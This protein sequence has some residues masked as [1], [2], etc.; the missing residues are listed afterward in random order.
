MLK[1]T[2]AA[3]ALMG[4]VNFSAFAD[5]QHTISISGSTSV[6]RV[7]DVLAETYN[8]KHENIF[9]AVHGTGSSAGIAAVKSG[10]TELG[11]S[12]RFLKEEE[13]SPNLKLVQIAHD[14]ITMVVHPSNT[15]ENLTSAQIKDIY[16][17]KIT[18]W[19]Q[20]GGDD[21][22]MAVVS[23]ENASGTRFSFESNVD[24]LQTLNGETVSDI[25]R[26]IL[27]ANTNSMVKTLVNHNSHAIGYASLGSVDES[28]KAVDF[29]GIDPSV[30]NVRKGDYT[31][32]R[33][34]LIMHKDGE[35][36]K[37]AQDFIHFLLSDEGQTII[38]ELG[39]ISIH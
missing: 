31:L 3:F 34:F 25:S 24:L 32:S 8:Q 39:Y 30:Q 6:S 15:I 33:P 37:E 1:K 20:V 14:A 26:Q 5:N 12:S 19:S 17:E 16:Q 4:L 23:R 35:I 9:V 38:E 11:M 36:S 2:A 29:N 28:I 13:A 21:S 18:N 27:I 22:L 7:M 10:A